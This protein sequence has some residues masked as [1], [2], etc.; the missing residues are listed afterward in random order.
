MDRRQFLTAAAAGGAAVAVL[1]SSASS[2]KTST[3]AVSPSRTTPWNA[4]KQ[5]FDIE[6]SIVQMSAFYLASHPRPVREAIER[7]RRG[8]DRDSHTYIEEKVA[9]LERAVRQEASRYMGVNGDDLAFTDSTTMGLGLVY[10]GFAL[11]P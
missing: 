1:P 4:I 7:H 8:L 11:K 3:S 6:P 10:S 5:Q 9:P 2:Q